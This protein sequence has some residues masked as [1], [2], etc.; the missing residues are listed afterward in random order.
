MGVAQ[1]RAAQSGIRSR[2]EA[3]AQG[4]QRAGGRFRIRIQQPESLYAVKGGRCQ[5]KAQCRIVAPREAAVLGQ[6]Q[7]QRIRPGRRLAGMQKGGRLTSVRAPQRLPAFQQGLAF[8]GTGGVVGDD[9][10]GGPGGQGIQGTQA[11]QGV[12]R[13]I[14]M[15]KNHGATGGMQVGSRE[16]HNVLSLF[17][18]AF[19]AVKHDAAQVIFS[20]PG[21]TPRRLWRRSSPN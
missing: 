11:G 10:A 17:C 2:V 13:G 9:H 21:A 15:H 19:Q 12:A 8:S 6:R 4:V 7:K 5:Q 3:R 16:R 18:A 20:R 14:V 1:R